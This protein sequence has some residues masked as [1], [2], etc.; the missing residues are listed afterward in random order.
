MT[1]TRIFLMLWIKI[2]L[3]SEVWVLSEVFSGWNIGGANPY[4]DGAQ[5][6]AI[7]SMWIYIQ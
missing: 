3:L 6:N 1:Q 4:S 7:I 5:I 2:Q